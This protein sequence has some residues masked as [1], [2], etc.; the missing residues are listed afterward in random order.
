MH[1]KL[2]KLDRTIET[3]FYCQQLMRLKREIDKKRPK[4]VKIIVKASSLITW[5]V[6]KHTHKFDIFSVQHGPYTIIFYHWYRLPLE[7]LIRVRKSSKKYE[8]LLV[9]F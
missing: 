7:Y 1:H 5:C 8:N 9:Q 2:F 4:F 6:S 3:T